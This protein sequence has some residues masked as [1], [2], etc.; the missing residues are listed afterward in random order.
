MRPCL[1]TSQTVA[2]AKKKKAAVKTVVEKS[3]D[4]LFAAPKTSAQKKSGGLFAAPKGKT[5]FVS[6]TTKIGGTINIVQPV[7][8]EGR[9]GGGPDTANV[10]PSVGSRGP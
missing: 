7:G 8:P 4:G 5:S 3:T 10:D 2:L 9:G 6:D 1:S